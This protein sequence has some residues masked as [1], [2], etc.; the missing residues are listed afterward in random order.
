MIARLIKIITSLRLTVTLLAFGI[1]LVF[2]G[3]VAQADEGLYQAQ[4]RYFKHWFVWGITFF[5]HRISL[6]LPGGYLIGTLLLVN[7]TAAHIQ[8]FQW[9]WK[10]AGIHL[11]HV[12]I[13]LLLV[14][15]LATDLLSRETQLRFAE[16][17]TKSWSESAMDYELA[18][19]TD[20]DATNEQVVAI[21]AQLLAR[22][23]EIKF[24]KLPFAVRVKLYWPNSEPNFR[25]P[26]QEN[27]PPLTTNGIARNFDFRQIPLTHKMD[28][29]NV[30]TAVVELS[31]NGVPT[32]TWVVSGWAGD[33][34]M[35]FGLRRYYAERM[36][37]QMAS[38]IVSR[39]TEPQLI[40]AGGKTVTFTLRPARTY[41]PYS[42]TLLKATH[43]VY[44]GTKTP[45][46][47]RSRV[48][49]NNPARGEDREVEIYMNNPLRYAGLTFFQHQMAAGE[50]AQELGQIPSSTLQVVRN[51]GWITPYAGC[52]IVAA[53]LI[54][55]FMIHL[56][57]FVSKRAKA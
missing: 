54:T 53:G 56:V 20:L 31:G 25:A 14:G 34:T 18:F 23:G 17:E 6:P 22:G 44:P 11:T 35:V 57:G 21:P 15:Q 16:G 13:V 12:G 7:L 49:I 24:E 51:P 1:V 19:L 55:Q 3:T 36:T 40:Q 41:K 37:E 30:P 48:R 39:L 4:A 33:E 32:G 27:E 5:G 46:D 38:T 42:L 29:K 8:R 50:L 10:K 47:Y 26:T 9:T 43:A 28:D 2:V 45:K 52:I